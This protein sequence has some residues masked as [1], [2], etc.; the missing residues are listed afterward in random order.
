VISSNYFK[1]KFARHAAVRKIPRSRYYKN[2]DQRRRNPRRHDFDYYYYEPCPLCGEYKFASTMQCRDCD[3]KRR[4]RIR[5]NLEKAVL[6]FYAFG[7]SYLEI[8][9]RFKVSRSR[10]EAILTSAQNR[11]Q[12]WGQAAVTRWAVRTGLITL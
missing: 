7:L 9:V 8:A 2:N 4:N 3:N 12:V 1:P 6:M 11:F 10:I 5:I